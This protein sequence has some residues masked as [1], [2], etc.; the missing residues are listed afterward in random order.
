M[1]KWLVLISY[2]A[3][4]FLNGACWV[5]LVSI[6]D[7]AMDY[8]NINEGQLALYEIIAS[9]ISIPLTP[10]SGWLISESFYYSL[11]IV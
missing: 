5:V 10:P 6:P 1:R 2:C 9:V 3:A 8:Y 11:H 4:S 7:E